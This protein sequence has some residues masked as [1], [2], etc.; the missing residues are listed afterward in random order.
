MK[1]FEVGE[2]YNC[3]CIGDHNIIWSYKVLRRTEKTI[4]I[5]ETY[6][7]KPVTRK[8]MVRESGEF[9]YPDGK[10]SMCPVLSA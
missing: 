9:V 2:I 6:D 7:E 8:I 3:R 1:K 10:Y 4:T 5:Q